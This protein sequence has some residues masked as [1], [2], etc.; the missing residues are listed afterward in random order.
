MQLGLLMVPIFLA[1]RILDRN[2]YY[3]VCLSRIVAEK[4]K[5]NGGDFSSVSI[6]TDLLDKF[7]QWVVGKHGKIHGVLQDEL[8]AAIVKHMK[9]GGG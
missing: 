8:E 6:R 3:H 4:G 9:S 2:I 1:S 7:R 5:E